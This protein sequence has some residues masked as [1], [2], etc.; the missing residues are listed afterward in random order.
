MKR[1]LV[2]ALGM[3]LAATAAAP[4]AEPAQGQ[5]QGQPPAFPPFKV[6]QV[7]VDRAIE[8]GIKYLKAN[9]AAHLARFKHA[10]RDMQNCELVLWTYVHAGVPENDPA[11]KQLFDDMMARKLEATYCVSLQAMILEEIQRVKYQH[12]IAQCAQF[13]VDN[14]STQ[15]FWGYGDPS[16][17]VEDVPT[18]APGRADVSSGTGKPGSAKKFDELPPPGMRY[19]PPVKNKMKIT[20][21]REGNPNDNSNTQYA[22]LGLRACH[23]A[24]IEIEAKV[25]DALIDWYRKTQ[26]QPEPPEIQLDFRDANGQPISKGQSGVMDAAKAPPAGWCYGQ[27]DHKAYGSMTAGSMGG[28][29]IMLYIKDNDGGKRRSWRRDKDVLE[30]L[31]WLA[32]NFSVTYNPGP[33]EHGGFAENSQHQ[34]YYYLYALERAGMLF[35]T[36]TMGTHEWYPEGAKVL[37]ESQGADGRWGGGVVDTCFAILFLK[38]ATRPLDVATHS[39]GARK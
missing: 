32:K 26:K 23:D 10:E 21:K 18:T 39:A 38:R 24:G 29:A 12:R 9:N 35:G 15:G 16:I 33:Y 13:L 31:A 8:N 4:A 20:K 3:A 37:I 19:K 1:A 14:Q 6:D 25:I 11:F 7:K 34:Y 5:G 27:H 2:V 22:T 17:F 30:G 36:E 28:L